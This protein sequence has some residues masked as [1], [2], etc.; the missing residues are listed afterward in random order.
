[1]NIRIPAF[2]N[3]L[4]VRSTHYVEILWN[5]DLACHETQ[6][7]HVR[8]DRIVNRGDFDERLTGLDD[9]EWF[10]LASPID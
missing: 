5:G 7:P 9:D 6:S 10:A 3:T 2:K 8:R 1:M 4:Y